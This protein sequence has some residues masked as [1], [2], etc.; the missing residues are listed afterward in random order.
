M[1]QREGERDWRA[2]I[3]GGQR[4]GMRVSERRESAQGSLHL[5]GA[6]PRKVVSEEQHVKKL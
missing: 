5:D 4:Q 1:D 2:Q 3:T 6:E